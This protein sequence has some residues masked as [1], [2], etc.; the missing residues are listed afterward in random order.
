V[1]DPRRAASRALI[2][3]AGAGTLYALGLLAAF[4]LHRFDVRRHH[5]ESASFILIALLLALVFT[6]RVESEE[7]FTAHAV[8]PSA[9][10]LT[11]AAIGLA[12]LQYWPVVGA[13][14]FADDFVLLEAAR[15]GRLTVWSELFRPAIFVVWRAVAALTAS[16]AAS[17]HLLNIVLHGVNAAMV[18]ALVMRMGLP[19]WSIVSGVLFL[20]FPPAVEAVAW[21]AGLQDVLMT[22][23]VLAFLLSVMAP[24]SNVRATIGSLILLV[25]A[26]LTKE[27][28]VCA[29]MLALCL[30][31]PNQRWRDTW[32]RIGLAVLAVAGFLV[33]RMALLPMP[34]TFRALPDRYGLKELMVRP[35][36][37]LLVPL[38]T[39]EIEAFPL[40]ALALAA[41]VVIALYA[42][43]IGWSRRSRAFHTTLAAVCAIF[44]AVAP[45]YSYFFVTGDMQ[46]TRYLYLASA[47]WVLL[48]VNVLDAA[49]V[50]HRLAVRA[51]AAFLVVCGLAATRA[52]IELWLDAA[53]SRDWI[54]ASAEARMKAPCAR[55]AVFGLPAEIR[56]VPAFVNGF[57][58][59]MRSRTPAPIRVAPEDADPA[60]CRLTWTG[61]NF[62]D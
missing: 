4:Y 1:A 33:V 53:E 12:L 26:L 37:T 61:G 54:V 40:V 43:A 7:P 52:H 8:M 21:P 45:V 47:S 6:R 58:E 20:V 14:L 31:F 18:G 35:F 32:Q 57:P 46:G 42:A 19:N 41:V 9:R 17:M 51:A 3:L 48:A 22:T 24:G 56:G 36:Q 38:R 5:I 15:Q 29:P 10:V 2:V 11:V 13:G 44:A 16:P 49:T 50:R 60:E 25:A 55:W 28:A 59:A 39:S 30:C 23:F 34:D 27:T 62:R